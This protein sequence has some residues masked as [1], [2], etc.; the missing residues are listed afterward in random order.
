MCDPE[1]EDERKENT[2]MNWLVAVGL[3]AGSPFYALVWMD[4]HWAEIA[5][6]VYLCTVTV[7]GSLLLFKE[8]RSLKKRWLWIGMVPLA[9]I[10]SAAMYLLVLFNEAFPQIDRFPVATYGLLVPLVTLEGV[11]LYLILERFRPRKYTK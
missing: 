2:Q 9:V 4:H 5:L 1:G 11:I 10:H 8:K 7:F 6:K 3:A